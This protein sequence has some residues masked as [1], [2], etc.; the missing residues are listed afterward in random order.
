[1]AKSSNKALWITLAVIAFVVLIIILT[2]W[3]AY[4]RFVTLDQNVEGKWSEVENQYQR[5]S[6]LIPNLV[7]VT[8]SSISVETKFVKDVI[9]QRTAWQNAQSTVD[10][11]KAGLQMNSGIAAFVNA[12]AESYPTLQANKQYVALT[13][14]LSGTQN[15]IANSRREYINAVQSFNT[16]IKRFP[17][18]MIAGMYGFEAK[19]YYQASGDLTT[20]QIGTGQLPQ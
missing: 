5:Q 6:D 9:A 1:M 10:K 16:A 15:R 4:N 13:D 20:P 14:E 18:N 3:G 17:G 2:I 19:E 8:A 7:S 11:D 12:V